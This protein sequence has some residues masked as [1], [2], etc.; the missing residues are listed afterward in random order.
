MFGT[1]LR[2]HESG[3]VGRSVTQQI[4]SVGVRRVCSAKYHLRRRKAT[5]ASANCAWGLM[6]NS[7]KSMMAGAEFMNR[8]GS[9]GA[10]TTGWSRRPS[11]APGSSAL[12]GLCVRLLPDA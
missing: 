7:A 1:E 12:A 11:L 5:L 3:N 10:I 6:V 8:L 2:Y 9:A 4:E